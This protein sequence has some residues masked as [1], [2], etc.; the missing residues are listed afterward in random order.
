MIATRLVV[1]DPTFPVPLAS[2]M[3]QDSRL[4][5]YSRAAQLNGGVSIT[6]SSLIANPNLINHDVFCE[7]KIIISTALK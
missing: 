3:I 4:L 6:S 1:F 2:E 5:P 7:M